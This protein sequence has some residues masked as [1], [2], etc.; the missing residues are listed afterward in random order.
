MLLMY[1]LGTVGACLM[2][3]LFKSTLLKG[4]KP[5]FIMELPPYRIPSFNNLMIHTW[6]KTKHFI[7]KA[8][9]TILAM[10]IIIWF[11]LNT[12]FGVE[13]KKDSY[14]G[15]TAQ[16]IAPIFEPLGFGTW[17]ATSAL[18]TGIVAKEVIISTMAEVFT[19]YEPETEKTVEASVGEE[20][21]E[22]VI[23]FFAAA[24]TAVS[25]VIVTTGI[26][27]ITTDETEKSKS[28]RGVIRSEFVP[29]GA[30]SF[31]VFVLL[32]MPCMVTGVAIKHEFG[33]WKL[34]FIATAYGMILA[35]CI[36][37]LVF[38]IGSWLQIGG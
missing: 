2:A 15:K 8:G 5:A 18:V 3:W 6:E 29:L 23:S 14:L 11:T 37:F 33:S 17:E 12:P 30:Y 34:F 21:K 20:L 24:K 16:V 28:L 4:Q 31:M 1:F 25:N 35:W 10:S 9:T 27:T 19:T 7:I 36:S 13:H 26:S 22:I 38:Q 32:Y